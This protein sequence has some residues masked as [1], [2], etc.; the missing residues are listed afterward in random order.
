M[1][2]VNYLEQTYDSTTNTYINALI[3]KE[4]YDCIDEVLL[5]QMPHVGTPIFITKKFSGKSEYRWE[6]AKVVKQQTANGQPQNFDV[7]LIKRTQLCPGEYLT[8]ILKAPGKTAMNVL[9][10]FAFVEVEYGHP[11]LVG[12]V[13]GDFRSNKRYPDS[14]QQGSMPKRRLAIVNRVITRHHPVV[15]VVPIST[16]QPSPGDQSAI[17]VTNSLSNMVHY[18][19]QSWAICSMI[20]TISAT[21]IIAPMARWNGG[22]RGRDTGFKHKLGKTE[23]LVL[24]DALMHGVGS[25]NR[26]TD[27][28]N[29][30]QAQQNLAQRDQETEQLRAQVEALKTRVRYVDTYEQ[31]ARDYAR[32][33]GR[34]FEGFRDEFHQI[35]APTA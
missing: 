5:P 18:N 13:N 16:V 20:E 10:R 27:S 34:P 2:V 8:Q 17:E 32:D 1:I 26:V 19:R 24:A 25:Q 3:G 9:Q 29:L 4:T 28:N 30:I 35:Y 15:Q 7:V 22:Y 11:P 23:R 31:M 6:V 12:K 33:I 21:R 14:V